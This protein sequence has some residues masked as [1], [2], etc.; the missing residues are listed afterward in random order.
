MTAPRTIR[1]SLQTCSA[2]RTRGAT[3]VATALICL[4]CIAVPGA[5]A[6]P[7]GRGD[8]VPWKDRFGEPLPF[9]S[10][11][12]IIE[13]LRTA[14]IQSVEDLEVGITDPRRVELVKDG[15]TMRAALR[16]F[17]QTFERMRFEREF[18]N[19]LRDSY[20]FDI[21]VYELS[22]I[23][24]LNNVPP[25]TLR[26]VNGVEASLQIWVEDALVE[27]DRFEE[28]IMPPDE[29]S[30]QMQRQNMRVFDSVIGNVDRNNGNILYDEKWNHWLI[31]HSRSFVPTDEKMPYL[32]EINWCARSL[33]EGLKNL[34]SDELIE[35][36]S[37]TLTATDVS[38]MLKRRDKVIARLDRLIAERG[39]NK[40][41]F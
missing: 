17:D 15:V 14:E 18:Y 41:L 27:W 31:D 26:Q 5:W 40:V 39:V 34:E 2:A 6:E 4:L 23:L 16:D 36:L 20:T 1:E 7:V 13:F 29:M 22:K 38:W 10:D 37:P 12:E 21:A 25:V 28:A 11:E 19:R 3:A 30:F 8:K 32:E 9:Q 33:Y 24:G 35:R